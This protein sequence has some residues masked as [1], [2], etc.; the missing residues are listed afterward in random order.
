VHKVHKVKI[1]R[2]LV[3]KFSDDRALD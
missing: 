2:A 1:I 3:N